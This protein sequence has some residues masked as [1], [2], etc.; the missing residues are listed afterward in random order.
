MTFAEQLTWWVLNDRIASIDLYA[1]V[2][3]PEVEYTVKVIRLRHPTN[4]RYALVTYV[5]RSSGQFFRHAVIVFS[6]HGNEQESIRVS[7]KE[8]AEHGF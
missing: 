2:G 4:D 3:F 5:D 8:L 7:M 1:D 6:P